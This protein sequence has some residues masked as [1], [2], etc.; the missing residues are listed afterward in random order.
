[1]S[2]QI[3]P[4]SKNRTRA[5]D[6]II[7]VLE[8]RIASGQLENEKPL[9]AER[10]LM[11]EFG[12]SRTVVREAITTLASRGLIET[13][14]G[15]RPIVRTP[16]YETMIDGT[17]TVVRYM[18]S[19]PR[20][21]LDLY[22]CRVFIERGLVRDAA[23]SADKESIAELKAALQ[24]NYEAIGDGSLFFKTDMEF[25]EVL[26]HA[27]N[28]PIFPAVHKAFATWLSPHWKKMNRSRERDEANYLAHKEIYD[29]ILERDP[30]SAEAALSDHLSAAWDFVKNTFDSNHS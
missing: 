11:E 2:E 28:N 17:A 5:A 18:L 19:E 8:E 27:S 9:P 12:I 23:N 25:H 15:F 30:D 7:A 20:G 14:P 13:R 6:G 3:N 4:D 22:Q 26:F 10:I 24:R 1:M 29:A 21:V 16:D